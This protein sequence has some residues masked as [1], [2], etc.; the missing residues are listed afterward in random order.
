MRKSVV[1]LALILCVIIAVPSCYATSESE[2]VFYSTNDSKTVKQGNSGIFSYKSSCEMYDIYYIIDFDE[3]YVYNF[4][5][6]NGDTTCDRVKI[7]S[8]DLNTVL[9]ITYHDG[10][11]EWS[12]GLHFNWRNQPDHL[13]LQ[14]NDGFES[15]FV[16][17][18]LDKAL[19]IRDSLSIVDY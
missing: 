2:A 15:D 5:D 17:T 7:D 18:D 3:K 8:G 14:D 16:P 19:E 9:I 4:L 13:I 10:K 11:D 12:N 1:A 6:G